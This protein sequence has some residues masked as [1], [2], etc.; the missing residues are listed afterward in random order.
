MVIRCSDKAVCVRQPGEEEEIWLPFS[1]IEPDEDTIR[2]C[3]G[4]DCEIFVPEWL[5]RKTGLV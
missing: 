5:E 4:T 2:S 3:I 1:Q